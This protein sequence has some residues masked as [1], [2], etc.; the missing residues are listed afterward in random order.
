MSR[1]RL[2]AFGSAG[3]I[4]LG[5]VAANAHLMTVAILSQPDCVLV[6][7]PEEGTAHRAAKPSC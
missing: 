1:A 4:V 6:T 5:F 7:S 3:L 2:F